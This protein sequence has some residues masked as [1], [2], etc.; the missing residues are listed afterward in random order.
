MLAGQVKHGRF[1]PEAQSVPNLQPLILE[2]LSL[3]R[4]TLLHQELTHAVVKPTTK[5]SPLGRPV[6][7][8][9]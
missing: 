2:S 8:L 6:V 9:V 4:Q 5:G 1:V 3:D 7:P